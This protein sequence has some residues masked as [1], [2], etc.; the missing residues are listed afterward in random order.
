LTHCRSAV[1]P[2]SDFSPF[3]ISVFQPPF[4]TLKAAISSILAR[5]D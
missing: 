4:E 3:T 1:R 2:F 5:P